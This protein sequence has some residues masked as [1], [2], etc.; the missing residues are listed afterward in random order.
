MVWRMPDVWSSRPPVRGREVHLIDVSGKA[1][2]QAVEALSPL[3]RIEVVRHEATYEGGLH[4]IAE[5]PDVG[6][7]TLVLFLGSNIG[8]FDR[9][10][11]EEFLRTIRAALEPGDSLLLGADLV[12]PEARAASRL[13]RSARRHGGV[14][15]QSPRAHQPRTRRRRSI[16][17]RSA[18]ERSGTR[19]TRA[20]KCISSA[21]GVSACA[22]RRRTS[23]SNRKRAKRSG[24]RALT[25]MDRRSSTPC[26]GMQGLTQSIPGWP[27]KRDSR[28]RSSGPT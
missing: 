20:W 8:N 4:E 3:E 6:G 17:T 19:P 24:P 23:T 2:D 18:T 27:P 26:S 11:A 13:R 14:Q 7:S 15:P 9:P 1:L 28:S 5:A 21:G 25:N 10:G 16:W 12:K 22:F